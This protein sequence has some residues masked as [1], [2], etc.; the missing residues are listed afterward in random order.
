MLVQSG[1]VDIAAIGFIGTR[2]PF[3]AKTRQPS[4]QCIAVQI[5]NAHAQRTELGSKI[6]QGNQFAGPRQGE[7]SARGQEAMLVQKGP[8]SGR[9]W[10]DLRT[11]ITLGPERCRASRGMIA[12]AILCFEQHNPAVPG[13]TRS[14]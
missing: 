5:V 4:Q 13:K 11:A 6:G 12:R 14:Q 1:N 2:D 3:I 7:R 9:Q 8:R 10:L